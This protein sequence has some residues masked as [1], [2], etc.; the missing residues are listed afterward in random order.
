VE[1][2]S[3]SLS[4]GEQEK[5][6]SEM[7][8][9]YMDYYRGRVRY[10][11][12]NPGSLTV[13]PVLYQ[14]VTPEFPV[15][16]Q[17]TDAIH[18]KS[19]ADALEKLYPESEYVKTLRS[20]AERRTNLLALRA[21]IDSAEQVNYPEIELPDINGKKVKLTEVG[22]KVVLLHFWTASDAQQKMFNQDVLKKLYDKYHSKGLQIYQVA[23]DTDKA[24]WASTVK[25]QE[26]EWI[27]VCDVTGAASR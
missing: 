23:L 18:F 4:A 5:L 24:L 25:S 17:E 22:S 9:S 12:E 20:E 26:L 2:E 16:A 10:I 1:L 21:R 19:A 11:M 13:V 6:R 7:W 8:K 14:T 15:F 27:N 3:G